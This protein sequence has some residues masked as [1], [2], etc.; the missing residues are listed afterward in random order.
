[1]KACKMLRKGCVGYWCYALEVKEEEVRVENIP[2]VCEFP[3]VF[4]EEL[5]GLPPQREINFEIE[6]ILGAQP[7]SKAPYRMAPTKLKDLKTQLEELLQKGFI[8]PS[9]S[10]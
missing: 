5:P 1:M 6:L 9:V 4:P 8:R 10:P 2:V 7:I 3:D